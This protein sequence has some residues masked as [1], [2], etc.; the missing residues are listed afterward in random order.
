MSRIKSFGEAACEASCILG[1]HAIDV[2]SE[3]RSERH[4]SALE[5]AAAL[6]RSL[7]FREQIFRALEPSIPQGP[8]LTAGIDRSTA[9]RLDQLKRQLRAAVYQFGTE[10]DRERET[11]LLT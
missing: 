5:R 3:K 1:N 8:T 7:D 2:T 4:V 11:W 9:S 10:L 6:H